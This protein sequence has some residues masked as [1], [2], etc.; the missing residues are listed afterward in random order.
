MIE[1]WEQEDSANTEE[2]P[3]INPFDE[4]SRAID[5]LTGVFPNVIEVIDQ[6]PLPMNEET[7]TTQNASDEPLVSTD[8]NN[9]LDTIMRVDIVYINCSAPTIDMD[10]LDRMDTA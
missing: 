9:A 3:D 6:N 2:L 5:P 4:A 8:P 10:S 7:P 1:K